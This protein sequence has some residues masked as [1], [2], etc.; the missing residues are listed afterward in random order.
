[1]EGAKTTIREIYEIR[2]EECD[3]EL[4]IYFTANGFLKQMVRNIVGTI[5]DVGKGRYTAGEVETMLGSCDRTKAGVTAP[6]HGLYLE[7]VY[8]E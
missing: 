7:H 1:M 3:D 4:R 8:Y 5:V 2:F 6:A